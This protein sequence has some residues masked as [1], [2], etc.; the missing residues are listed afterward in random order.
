MKIESLPLLGTTWYERGFRYWT[1]RFGVGVLLAACVVVYPV[2]IE[3]ASEDISPQGTALYDGLAAAEVVFTIATG[4]WLFRRLWRNS[5]EGKGATRRDTRRAGRAG[6]ALGPLAFSMGGV[7]AG[8]LVFAS[9]LTA[10]LFLAIFVSWIV[11]VPPAE[12]YARREIAGKIRKQ[13]MLQQLAPRS[14]HDGSK[15]HHKH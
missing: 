14:K 12:Q 3:A 4:V 15:S 1:R 5:L 10:G 6:G 9:L 11:P 13:H 8:L 7:L 2:M